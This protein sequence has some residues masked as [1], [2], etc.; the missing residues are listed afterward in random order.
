MTGVLVK[1]ERLP[2]GE[3]LE[4]C[5]VVTLP[6]SA[7]DRQR[8]R[9][10]IK[11]SDGQEFALA[12]PTGTTLRVGAL[13]YRREDKAYV[14]GA[15]PEDV[16]VV[17]PRNA[18]EAARVGHLI[19]NLHR[20]L[21]IGADG[22]LIALWTAPLEARLEREGFR[23]TRESRAFKGR[24]PGEHAHGFSETL[25]TILPP[26]YRDGT[27]VSPAPMGSAGLKFG[28]DGKVLWNEM[29][30]SF[31]DLALAGGP[32]HRGTL[33]EPPSADE[34]RAAPEAYAEVVA[35]I[36]RGIGLVTGLE[37]LE[38]AAPGW[39]G[40]QCRDEAMAVWLL[41]AIIVE[42]VMVRRQ[43]TVLYLP[44]GPSYRLGREIKNVVTVIAKTHHYYTE[45]LSAAG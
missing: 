7:E 10:R 15:A 19:G 16:L 6:M 18:A 35:E 45:H 2:Q 8:V 24:P 39:V 25:E 9:R 33:L 40:V 31:C 43:G 29:W 30:G 38:S 23:V 3:S 13:L 21:D 41:R 27:A 5:T 42:N 14:V 17:S 12:L 4:G 44:A 28:E 37:T 11:A 20:D 1:L 36:R 22:E 34:V 26:R 32:T